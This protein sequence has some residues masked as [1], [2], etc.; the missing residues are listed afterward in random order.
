M[1]FGFETSRTQVKSRQT[2]VDKYV[3][4]DHGK[5]PESTNLNYHHGKKKNG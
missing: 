5:N 4:R 2:I 1:C 3:G